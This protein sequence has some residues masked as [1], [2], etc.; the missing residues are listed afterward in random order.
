[1]TKH[2]T[3]LFNQLILPHISLVSALVQRYSANPQLHCDH[4]QECLVQLW[5]DL[6]K[7][8]P[9][10]GDIK[11][12]IAAVCRN[13]V[14]DLYRHLNR[15]KQVHAQTGFEFDHPTCLPE[16]YHTYPDLG[17]ISTELALALRGHTM[18]TIAKVQDIPIP[19]VKSRLSRE[20][21]RLQKEHNHVA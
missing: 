12:W 15:R 3:Q 16:T 4:A 13:K 14:R 11:A 10:L 6:D 20:R 1:M 19:T 21:T 17:P 7:Y 5:K 2:N 8:N 18:V 9:A